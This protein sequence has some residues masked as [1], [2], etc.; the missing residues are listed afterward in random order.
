MSVDDLGAL[1]PEWEK[2]LRVAGMRE[3]ELLASDKDA[4]EFLQVLTDKYHA[5]SDTP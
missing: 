2:E 4:G 3:E 1:F 5:F